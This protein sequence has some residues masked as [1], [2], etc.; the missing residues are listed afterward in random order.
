MKK[1]FQTPLLSSFAF[2]VLAVFYPGF[3]FESNQSIVV[4]AVVFALLQMFVRPILKLLSFPLNLIT[5]GLFSLFINVIILYLLALLVPSFSIVSFDFTGIDL[6]GWQLSTT[7]VGPL[8]SALIAS[9]L[10][11]IVSSLFFFILA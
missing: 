8:F 5:F 4:A 10:L 6:L 3:V 11:G 9:L 1:R 7:P 2:L